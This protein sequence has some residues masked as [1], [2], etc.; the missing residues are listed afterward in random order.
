MKRI[1]YDPRCVGCALLRAALPPT[2]GNPLDLWAAT[3]VAGA[4][5]HGCDPR[6]VVITIGSLAVPLP[7]S[8]LARGP[9]Q[10]AAHTR[11]SVLQWARERREA[12]VDQLVRA[13]DAIDAP[14]PE[15]RAWAIVAA[16]T[17]RGLLVTTIHH[18]VPEPSPEALHWIRLAQVPEDGGPAPGRTMSRG[19][20]A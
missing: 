8:E 18:D 1:L 4:E 13:I 19:G 6:D 10:L 17:P 3:V 2:V 11:A 7:L 20:R 16:E 9:Y 15:G 12:V 14:A 5:A